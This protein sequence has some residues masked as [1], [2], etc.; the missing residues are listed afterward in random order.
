[1]ASRIKPEK[2]SL[3]W[4]PLRIH[5]LLFRCEEDYGLSEGFGLNRLAQFITFVEQKLLW[6]VGAFIFEANKSYPAIVVV[7]LRIVV[8][9]DNFK[10]RR[11]LFFEIELHGIADGV[12]VS[13]DIDRK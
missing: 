10:A 7:D 5:L 9:I 12:A 11:I 6:R 1:M 13:V 3:F 2:D 4:K 8:H